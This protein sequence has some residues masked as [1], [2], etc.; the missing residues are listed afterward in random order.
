[1]KR[2]F[3]SLLLVVLTSTIAFAGPVDLEQAKGKAARFMKELNGSRIAA[4]AGAEYAPARSVKGK[5]TK[6]DVPAYYVFNVQ[7]EKGDSFR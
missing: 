2:R 6:T 5:R 1:M 3:F 4:D 7:D